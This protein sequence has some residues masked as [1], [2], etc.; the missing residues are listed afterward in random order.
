VNDLLASARHL[1]DK[2]EGLVF[3]G[4]HVDN[5]LQAKWEPH[6]TYLTRYMRGRKRVLFLGLNAGPWG[7]VQTGVPF[8]EV[9]AV[10]DWLKIDVAS[11]CTR[12][13]VSGQR[14]WGLAQTLFGS[15]AD[16]FFAEHAVM[17]YCPLAFREASGRN[18]TP[19]TLPAGEERDA[20]FEACD[21]HLR[22]AVEFL[23]PEV[24]IGI[25]RVAE[26]HARRLFGDRD[27]EYLLHPS[28]RSPAANRGWERQ[29]REQLDFLGGRWTSTSSR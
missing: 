10:R 3:S 20:L 24:V 17:N 8:G 6:E 5:P 1:R 28:P 13:E 15:S 23:N 26:G 7:M 18:R 19:D 22:D 16:A 9:N 2:V 14:F 25:G 4:L 21:E 11:D 27:I 12:S 29:A